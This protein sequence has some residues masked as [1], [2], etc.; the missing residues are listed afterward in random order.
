M[1]ARVRAHDALMTAAKIAVT[2]P[3][4]LLRRARQRVKAGRA[5]SMS[6]LVSQALD[7]LVLRDELANI[8]EE[9]DAE[10]GRAGQAAQAWA[11]RLRKQ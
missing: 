2:L 9:L 7:E 8:L 1:R 10:G 11:R 6:A 3:E 4:D 5:E